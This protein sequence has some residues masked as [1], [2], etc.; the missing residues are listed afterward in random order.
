MLI[1]AN[2]GN[3]LL[4]ALP[5]ACRV[6]LQSEL[7]ELT[8]S[9]GT[10]LFEPGDRI[11]QIYFPQ[12]GMVS[13]LTMMKDGTSIETAIVGREGAIGLT[14]GLGERRWL[15]RATIQVPGLFSIVRAARFEQAARESQVVRDL[16][17]QYTELLWAEAQQLTGCNAVHSASS[18]LCRWLL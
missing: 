9:Q 5:S 16:V 14:R 10:V 13:L 17:A 1:A 18:R 6:F 11:E 4:N 15:T 12:T 2:A 7:K 8:I 3:R